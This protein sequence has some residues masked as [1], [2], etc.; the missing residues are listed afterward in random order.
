MKH[1]PATLMTAGV[2]LLAYAV[3]AAIQ[4]KVGVIPVVGAYLPR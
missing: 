4:Q 1:L 3:V 2:A